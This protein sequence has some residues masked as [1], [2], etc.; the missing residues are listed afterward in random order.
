MYRYEAIGIGKKYAVD[1][2]R[3]INTETARRPDARLMSVVPVSRPSTKEQGGL[4][5][6]V[7]L[8][9]EYGPDA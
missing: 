5:T 2:A 4:T 3:A 6:E 1:I 7:V 8:T 9:F